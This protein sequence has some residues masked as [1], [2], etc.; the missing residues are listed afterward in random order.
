MGEY[1]V[2]NATIEHELNNKEVDFE[3]VG[4]LFV[5]GLI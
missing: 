1:G 2:L 3:A 4:N 5:G